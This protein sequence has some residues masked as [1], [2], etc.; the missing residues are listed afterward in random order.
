MRFD[1]RKLE[2][3]IIR[4]HFANLFPGRCAQYFDDLHQLIDARITWKDGLP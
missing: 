1:L 3:R 2:F 4:I